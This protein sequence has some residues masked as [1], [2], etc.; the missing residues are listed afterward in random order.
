MHALRAKI[1]LPKTTKK[2]FVFAIQLFFFVVFGDSAY[3]GGFFEVGEVSL[4]TTVDNGGW[5]TVTPSKIYVNPVIIVGPITHNN[6]LTLSPRVMGMQIGMQ[7]PC[8][9]VGSAAAGVVCPP[10]AGWVAETVSYMIV[11]EGV[12]EFPDET[13]LEAGLYSTATVRDNVA[14]APVQVNS[15]DLLAFMRTGFDTA[16]AIVHTVNSFNDPLFISSIAWGTGNRTSLPT[17]TQF[18][19]GLEGLEAVET[20]AA[21]NIAWLAIEPQAGTNAGTAYDSGITGLTYDRHSD[22]CVGVPNTNTFAIAQMNSVSGGN[23]GVLRRCNGALGFHVD[24]DQ[25]RDQERAGNTERVGY[26]AYAS[27]EFGNLVF[28]TATQSV[29]DNN[30]GLTQPGDTLTYT[31]TITNELNDFN[32]ADNAA[33]EMTIPLPPNTTLVGGSLAADSGALT[34]TGPLEWNGSV[35]PNQVITLTYQVTVDSVLAVCNADLDNQATLHM[36]PNGDGFN[37]IDELSDDPSR[38]DGIDTDMD[39]GSDDAGLGD[40][41]P[42]RIHVDCAALQLEKEVVNDNGGTATV[43]DF[44][45]TTDA[46]AL[47][48]T[49][50]PPVGNTTTYISN[51][52]IVPIGSYDLIESDLLGYSEGAWSCDGGTGIVTTFDA[53][54]ISL[55]TGEDVIC[56]II[57]DDVAAE[58]TLLKVVNNTTD[59]GSAVAGDWTLEANLNGGVA[60]VSGTSGITSSVNVGDYVLSELNGPSGYTQ[61]SLSCDAGTLIADTLSVSLGDEINCTFTNRD[62]ITDLVITKMMSDPNP[63]PGDTITF[64]LNV[65]N[66]GPDD[67]TNVTANDAVLAGF[68]FIS[69]SMTGGDLQNQTAPNLV[70]T[71]NSLPAGAANTVTLA[72]Q[73]TVVAP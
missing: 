52:L 10:A 16:P 73:V 67:A 51:Q 68:T 25:V 61:T 40:D 53:G 15:I 58:L 24:E 37:T 23:G 2:K 69:G 47:T 71:I 57:N 3:A 11:E 42:T 32:Q 14:G 33:D 56:T 60:E 55:A 6:D 13:E 31:V 29:V 7:S 39:N 12:W 9:S 54:S 1:D 66:N 21:E 49:N 28:L 27:E 18:S 65:V 19:L 38:D 46:G 44:S 35:A 50:G 72:Y 30:G 48:F 43:S 45:I 63:S 8:E 26:F 59:G 70:W 64:T 20:H 41:D 5:V 17:T 4:A 22:A 36:D 34:G 62:L